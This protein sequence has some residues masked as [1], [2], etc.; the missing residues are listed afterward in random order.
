MSADETPRPVW[1]SLLYVPTNNPRFVEK[2]HTRGADAIILDLE[3]A[4]P[5]AE[6]P[7][8]RERLAETVKS[9]GQAGADVVV[10]INREDAERKA[11][12]DAA[13][14][15]GVRAL[16]VAKC[17][18]PDYVRELEDQVSELEKA[19]NL[20]EGTVGFSIMV[21]SP[22][23][24]RKAADIGMA[25]ERAI[26]MSLGGEDFATEMHFPPDPET[27]ELPKLL[28]LMAAREA[29][30]MPLGFLGTV[31][32]YS[33]LDAVRPV[34][35][36]SRKFGFEGASCIHPAMVP[37]LNAAFAPTSDEVAWAERVVTQ[38]AE[39]QEKGLGAITVD[40]KMVDV[41]VAIRASRLLDRHRAIA[42]KTS[43][44]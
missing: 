41:P 37:L 24:L 43:G 13:V 16:F 2:A 10:R 30:L 7:A 6:R 15:S 9:V 29:G 14:V 18:S 4:C 40:G 25:S 42:I 28:C 23:A 34:L 33:D 44:G 12:L 8:A 35:S 39:A 31:A 17:D 36:R 1:R 32:D 38:Y 20:A 3:D 19:R 22:G 5:P 27:L 21:E 26:S 11:D